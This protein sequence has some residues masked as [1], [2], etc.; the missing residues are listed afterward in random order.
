MNQETLDSNL[1]VAKKNLKVTSQELS[2][3]RVEHKQL[4]HR[5][6]EVNARLQQLVGTHYQ[7]GGLIDTLKQ[8]VAKA[9]LEL[10][11]T[12]ARPVHWIERSWCSG[13]YLVQK[14]TGKRIYV[15]VFG[16]TRA[17]IFN[18]DGTTVS[19]TGRAK[20]DMT[21][22]FPEGVENFK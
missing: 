17:E 22:T 16:S 21:K 11:H 8:A 2:N 1:A 7:R 12:K 19:R 20:I 5:L 9:E 4:E 3:L 10:E 18:L 15:C 13:D 14:V 6:G